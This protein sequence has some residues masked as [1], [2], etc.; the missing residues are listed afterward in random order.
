MTTKWVSIIDYLFKKIK[1][2]VIQVAQILKGERN[3]YILTQVRL[4]K[5]VLTF[6][7][8]AIIKGK[9]KIQYKTTCL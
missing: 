9:K 1:L 2:D 4:K 3:F 5:I 7:N 6:Q 8:E